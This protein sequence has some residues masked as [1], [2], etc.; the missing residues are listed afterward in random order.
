[1]KILCFKESSNGSETQKE[2]FALTH[3]DDAH[4]MIL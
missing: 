2:D 4:E 1:M 3:D